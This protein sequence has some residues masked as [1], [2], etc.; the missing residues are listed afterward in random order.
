VLLV[1]LVPDGRTIAPIR[2][3]ISRTQGTEGIM[4]DNG[5][6]ERMKRTLKDAEVKR[7]HYE[8]HDELRTHLAD[9]ALAYNL[10][11]AAEDP[12]GPHSL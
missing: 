2:I 10:A 11:P 6:I 9:F 1:P 3:R 8:T 7:F 4:P 5:Q 12:E